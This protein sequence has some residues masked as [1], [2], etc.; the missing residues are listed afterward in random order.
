MS[1]LIH[2]QHAVVTQY[3]KKGIKGEWLVR[4]NIS[5][6]DMATLPN[7]ISDKDMFAVMDFARKFELE[8]FN[9][10]IAH[11][12]GV[13]NALLRT[14]IARLAEQLQYSESERA[15]LSLLL[16]QA[17]GLSSQTERQLIT[18]EGK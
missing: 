4:M 12:K 1:D 16:E 5:G 9:A 11:Q 7:S 17:Q 6:T 15:S 8:A 13:E 2:L 14:K 18:L 3:T 10:G